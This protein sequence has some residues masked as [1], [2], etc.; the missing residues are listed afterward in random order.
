MKIMLIDKQ[1][2]FF[3]RKSTKKVVQ[4]AFDEKRGCSDQCAACDVYGTD[5]KADCRRNGNN[6]EFMIGQIEG[7]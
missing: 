2:G 4:C 7:I 5:L 3:V 6:N 1:T